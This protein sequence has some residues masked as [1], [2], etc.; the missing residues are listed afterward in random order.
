MDNGLCKVCGESKD[1]NKARFVHVRL[2]LDEAPEPIWC[3]CKSDEA[4]YTGIMCKKKSSEKYIIGIGKMVTNRILTANVNAAE[5]TRMSPR[6]NVERELRMSTH[7]S[8][9]MYNMMSSDFF[10]PTAVS[11]VEEMGCSWWTGRQDNRIAKLRMRSD[12][13]SVMK[14]PVSVVEFM[15]GIKYAVSNEHTFEGSIRRPEYRSAMMQYRVD[16]ILQGVSVT[17]NSR[18]Y[19]C[20]GSVSYSSEIEFDELVSDYDVRVVTNEI[21]R[22]VGS[23][24]KMSNKVDP[25]YVRE[26]RNAD[27]NVVDVSDMRPYKGVTM[28]KVDGM[29]NYVFCYQSGYVVTHPDND[30]TVIRYS[31]SDSH[32][33]LEQISDRPGVFVVEGMDDGTM[34][35][36]DCLGTG[37]NAA[38]PVRSYQKRPDLNVATCDMVIRKSW[39]EYSLMPKSPV[40][41]LPSDGVVCV[42][43]FRTLRLKEPTV[44]LICKDGI[45]NMS[46]DGKMIPVALAST[47]MKQDTVYEFSVSPGVDDSTVVLSKGVSRTVKKRPNQSDIVRRAFVSVS[48]NVSNST[49]LY[50]IT[51]M[52]FKMRNRVYEDAQSFSTSTRRV[53]VMFGAGRFQEINEMRTDNYSYIAIDP[54]IDVNNISKRMKRLRIVPY[55]PNAD[56]SKQIVSITNRPRNLLYYAG[57]SESFLSCRGVLSCM[58]SMSIP[59]VFSFSLSYHV[60][61]INTLVSSGVNVYGCGYVHDYMPSSGVGSVPVTM[62]VETNDSGVA[63]VKSRFGKSE[64]VEPILLSNSIP[65]MVSIK[66]AMPELWRNIDSST[67]AIMSRAV[68]MHQ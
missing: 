17:I 48:R 62:K 38:D 33:P 39:S 1:K 20:E 32:M 59:A 49:V 11:E 22:V 47:A 55:D 41:S 15:P 63:V 36:I 4:I 51:S 50:D 23:D 64:W 14:V 9:V 60:S 67:Q 56:M 43:E 18:M 8:E 42:T 46:H 65:N 31:V 5:I 13:E 35:Y 61:V 34:V 12:G 52:S 29:K 10:G 28:V 24:R 53:I 25:E 21:M 27:H 40:T 54:N 44:D 37:G 16:I 68:I 30:L 57:T 45:L 19:D 3:R 7:V 6:P 26:V 66:V 2:G 58:S